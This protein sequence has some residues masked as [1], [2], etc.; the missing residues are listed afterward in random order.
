MRMLLMA[1]RNY[2]CN[3]PI[4]TIMSPNANFIGKAMHRFY[5]KKHEHTLVRNFIIYAE[6]EFR[7][8]I[9]QFETLL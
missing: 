9:I 5:T 6:A 7:N 1:L 8:F 3:V 4:A 2:G